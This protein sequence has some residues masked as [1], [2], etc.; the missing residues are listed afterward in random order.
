MDELRQWHGYDV[1]VGYC[2]GFV[3]WSLT[4][5]I[6]YS[7]HASSAKRSRPA[8]KKKP[9]D[10]EETLQGWLESSPALPGPHPNAPNKASLTA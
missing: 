8:G 6:Q 4:S 3:L 5:Y 2:I 7:V 9:Q 1:E 10:R